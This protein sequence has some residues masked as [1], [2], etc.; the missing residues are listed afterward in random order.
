[1]P[2]RRLRAGP[3][4]RQVGRGHPLTIGAFAPVAPPSSADCLPKLRGHTVY[5][6]AYPR[7][8]RRLKRSMVISED[9]RKAGIAM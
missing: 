7:C 3:V 5:E 2:K 8:R 6:L 1:M 4:K 9:A